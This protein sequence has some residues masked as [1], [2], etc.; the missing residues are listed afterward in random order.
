M[1]VLKI[2]LIVLMFGCL[3]VGALMAL[4]AKMFVGKKSAEKGNR[5]EL[6]I[7]LIGYVVLLCAFAFALFQSLIKF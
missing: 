5:K 4:G 2:I 3:A 7:R 1:R 6:R